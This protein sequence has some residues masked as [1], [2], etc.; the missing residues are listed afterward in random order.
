M[1]TWNSG[2]II[3]SLPLSVYAASAHDASEA[4]D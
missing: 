2:C 4:R 1:L 3:T